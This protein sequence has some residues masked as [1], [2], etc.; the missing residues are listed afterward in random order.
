MARRRRWAAPPPDDGPTR[1]LPRPTA[2]HPALVAAVVF[3]TGVYL[4]DRLPVAVWLWI[5]F[6]ACYGLAAVLARRAVVSTCC[7]VI[8]VAAIGVAAGQSAR[9]SYEDGEIGLY[10]GETP[11]LAWLELHLPTTPKLVRL[12]ET[13]V[14]RPPR[15]TTVAEVRRVKTHDGWTP[16]TG[17]VLLRFDQPVPTLAAGQ[18]VRV[19][20]TLERPGAAMNLGQFDFAAYY[21]GRRTLASVGV[22]GPANVTILN[23]DPP[24]PLTRLR[25][26]ARRSLLAGFTAQQAD[27]AALLRTLLLGDAD[28]AMSDDREIFRKSGTSHHLAVSGLHVAVIGGLAFF[29]ARLLGAGPRLSLVAFM[30]VVAGY[31]LLATPSPPVLRAVVLSL[32]FGL[33]LVS[34]RR[35]AGLNLLGVAA[36]VVL[37]LNPLDLYRAGFQLTFAVVLGLMLLSDAASAAMARHFGHESKSD[38]KLQSDP[39]LIRWTH[40]LDRRMIAAV[41]AGVVAWVV[42]TPLVAAH[43]EQFNPWAIPASLAVAPL[44]LLSLVGGV[45][46][47]LLTAAMPGLAE[48][49]AMLAA[50]P[51]SAMR[52]AVAQFAAMPGAEVPLPAPT[53]TLIV[54]FYLALI[55]WRLPLPTPGLRWAAR[56]PLAVSAWLI[57]VVPFTSADPDAAARGPLRVT[58]LAVGAGQCSAVETPAGR[59][60][61]V[62]VGSTSLGDPVEKCLSP[63]LRTTGHTAVDLLVLSHA[64][65]DHY[66][67]AADAVRT[68]DVGEVLVGPAVRRARAAVCDRPRDVG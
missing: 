38:L 3:A 35:G 41:A 47:L 48:F 10:T 2:A 46:K 5:A 45:L 55:L 20:G 22:D 54:G 52:W 62:D 29:L 17:T 64:N 18:R 56:G 50:W 42:A 15:L 37:W 7:L 26:S 27:E 13:P 31:A 1:V 65:L 58:M 28:P 57:F 59:L 16:A 67:G 51:V 39:W 4:H 53:P 66:G 34:R 25:E 63:F 9:Y 11:R 40:Y 19:F 49:W 60:A 44:V 61:L 21:R 8:G 32:A 33:G 43:F 24:S 12:D 36:I 68:Y 23:A 30:A 14:P 6:A